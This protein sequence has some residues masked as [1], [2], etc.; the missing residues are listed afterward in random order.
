MRDC[1]ALKWLKP[2]LR[3]IT[4]PFLVSFNLFEYDLFV[5]IIVAISVVF[6]TI[7]LVIE[8]SK[9]EIGTMRIVGA[10]D[11]FI[12]GPFVIQGIIYGVIAFLIC[13]IFSDILA[14]FLY[15]KLQTM[16]PGFNIFNYF[17]T[18]WWIFVLIQLGSGIGL[19]AISA[20]IVVKKYL[21][22]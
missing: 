1:L 17:L 18:N 3:A 16:L 19:G 14:Y 2:G 10:S 21:E 9:E 4:L 20:L 5:L 22:V 11:W 15:S 7:K 13:F 8:N 6:S 12:R